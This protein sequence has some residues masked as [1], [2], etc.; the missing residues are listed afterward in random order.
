MS[1][2]ENCYKEKQPLAFVTALTLQD[3]HLAHYMRKT[4]L[5]GVCTSK[6]HIHN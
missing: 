1:N 4:L 2:T 5:L 6:L 3:L